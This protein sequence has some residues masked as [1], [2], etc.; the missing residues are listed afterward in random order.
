MI[1]NTRSGQIPIIS[2]SIQCKLVLLGASNSGKTSLIT[3][4]VSNEFSPDILATLGAGL[5]TS[6]FTVNNQTVK[7]NIWDTAGQENYKSLAKIYY[8]DAKVVFLVFDITSSD[9]MKE[10][11]YW[12]EEMSSIS[13]DDKILFIIGNKIDME[14]QRVVSNEEGQEYANKHKATYIETSAKTGEN[15]VKAFKNAATAFYEASTSS[16]LP[17]TNRLNLRDESENDQ[18]CC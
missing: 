3:R 5:S 17:K 2:D 13:I 16:N 10:L 18:S 15:V 9:S 7:L 14:D 12:I 4:L 6:D 1:K 11:D 8:R